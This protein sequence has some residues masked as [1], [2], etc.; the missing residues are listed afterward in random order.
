MKSLRQ[1]LS[2]FLISAV[3]PLSAQELDSSQLSIDRLFDKALSAKSFGPVKWLEGKSG[4]TILEGAKEHYKGRKE[5]VFYDAATGERSVMVPA[6]RLI[7]PGKNS[8]IDIISYSFTYNYSHALI[9]TNSKSQELGGATG[10]YWVLDLL[11]W[12]WYRVGQQLPDQSLRSAKFS[13]DGKKVSYI[14]DNNIYA[15]DLT[16]YVVYQL[17]KDGSEKVLNG[18]GKSCNPS[19]LNH[20]YGRKGSAGYAWS[21]DSKYISYIQSDRTVVPYFYMLNNTETL[22]PKI[23]KFPYIKVGQQMPTYQV[24]LVSSDGLESKWLDV[25][26]DHTR[27]YLWQMQ[28]KPKKNHLIL[29]VLNREQKELNMYRAEVSGEVKKIHTEK[30]DAWIEPN[31]IH[32]ISNKDMFVYASETDGWSHRY[33]KS[34]NSSTGTKLTPGNFDVMYVHGVD[35]TNKWMYYLASPENPTQTYLFRASLD[36]KGTIQ[37]VTSDKWSG[38]NSYQISPDFKWA[39]H[40]FSTLQSPPEYRLVSLPDHKE[41]RVLEDNKKLK[42]ELAKIEKQP[43]E[44][45]KVDIGNGVELDGYCIKP[46]DMDENKKY[47]LVYHIY[48]EP[49]GQTVLDRW[50]GRQNFWHLMLAQKGYVVMSIDPRGTPSPKGRKWR[51]AIYGQLGWVAANDHAAATREIAKTRS[52]IDP[53]RVGIYG[54]SGG[55]QMSLNL[56]F[57]YPDL[58]HLAMPSSFVS[59]QK[60]YHPS[61]Q[62]RFMGQFEDNVEGYRKG[63]PISWAH[64]L[65]G[66]LLIIHGTGDSN[67][68]YQSYESLINELVD[69]KKRFTMM[70]YPNRNHALREGINTQF[71]LYDLRTNYL[72]ENLPSGPK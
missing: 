69:H 23:V 72:M 55:G 1:I 32:S 48:A 44:F 33:I 2:I 9:Y 70:A 15:D 59:H 66:K 36:G 46:P 8:P 71:H 53:G 62:E 60:L 68:H 39:I 5:I 27:D 57:R 12:D 65:K 11:L 3:L 18:T 51:K 22:Y 6:W 52:Y 4:Y 17:T 35:E 7:P 41:I 19:M 58:Y 34:E 61:Y 24:G 31:N 49:A 25:P 45:F 30:D 54:H 63:S 21:P 14:Y 29:Q 37:Q 47:P 26:G 16:S 28:W 43:T 64:N 40:T 67:V 42:E 10:D 20:R 56:I 13:P 50:R 38:T